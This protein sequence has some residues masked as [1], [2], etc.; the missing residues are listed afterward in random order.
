MELASAGRAELNDGDNAR[1]AALARLYD[2]DLSE[3]PGDLEL[4]LALASR[5]GG[6]IVELAVGTGRVAVPLAAAGHVVVGIDADPAM[7]DRARARADDAGGGTG[8]RLS[9][10]PQDMVGVTRRDLRPELADSARLAIL[11][12]NSILLLL[13]LA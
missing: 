6:P 8:G 2:L 10:L 11:A 5:T 1:D 9:L 3:D 4:Y 13:Q 7:L 12:L